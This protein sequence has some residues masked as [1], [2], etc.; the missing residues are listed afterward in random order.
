VSYRQPPFQI[1]QRL[2]KHFNPEIHIELQ[3][4]PGSNKFL[5]RGKRKNQTNND[6]AADG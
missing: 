3:Y 6:C 2:K 4:Y 1:L 5:M